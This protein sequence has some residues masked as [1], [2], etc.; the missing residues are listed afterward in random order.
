MSHFPSF[1][2]ANQQCRLSDFPH[3]RS[4]LCQP[5]RYLLQHFKQSKD[6]F[7]RNLCSKLLFFGMPFECDQYEKLFLAQKLEHHFVKEVRDKLLVKLN[8]IFFVMCKRLSFWCPNV[9]YVM[10]CCLTILY[11]LELDV[12]SNHFSKDILSTNNFNVML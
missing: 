3:F 9:L 10:F 8:G 7:P 1:R 2:S 5:S 4:H 11:H 12:K 6:V